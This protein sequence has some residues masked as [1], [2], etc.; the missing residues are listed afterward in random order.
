[1]RSLFRAQALGK[2]MACPQAGLPP[3]NGVN[4]QLSWNVATCAVSVQ[5]QVCAL[6]VSAQD[7]LRFQNRARG[8]G[9][10]NQVAGLSVQ[11]HAVN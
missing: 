5:V 6:T 7:F 2:P 9:W 3:G 11:G 8:H 1:M 4:S 10:R